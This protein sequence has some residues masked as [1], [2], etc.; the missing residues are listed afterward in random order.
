[1]EEVTVKRE[2]QSSRPLDA[3]QPPIPRFA[4]FEEASSLHGADIQ[5]LALL[6]GQPGLSKLDSCHFI[7]FQCNPPESVDAWI[8]PNFRARIVRVARPKRLN[9]KGLA[10][11]VASE[12]C[13]M[14][15]KSSNIW[16]EKDRF[17]CAQSLFKDGLCIMTISKEVPL[18][19]E[20]R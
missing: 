11:Y 4:H 19:L 7:R 17:V 13:R 9:N 20:P 5:N 18:A 16:G 10:Q 8:N 15:C 1:M 3:I 2:S 6:D 14:R 12:K